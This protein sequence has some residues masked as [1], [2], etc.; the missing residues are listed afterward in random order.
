MSDTFQTLWSKTRSKSASDF[1]T[2]VW[3][4]IAADKRIGGGELRMIEAVTDDHFSQDHIILPDTDTWHIVGNK[5][6]VRNIVSRVQWRTDLRSFFIGYSATYGNESE[7]S[8]RLLAIKHPELG[9]TYPHLTIQAFLDEHDGHLLSVAA[10]P[11]RYLIEQAERLMMWNKLQDASDTRY[12]RKK[13]DHGDSLY[14]SWRYLQRSQ[15]AS[16]ILVFDCSVS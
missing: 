16:H 12:G 4:H 7:Y 5:H 8:R 10:I 15:V 14:L 11:T 9:L 6:N 3:P 1:Q 2:I 13:T